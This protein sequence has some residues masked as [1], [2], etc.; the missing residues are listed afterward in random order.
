MNRRL[1]AVPIRP[2][3]HFSSAIAALSKSPP[4][5]SRFTAFGSACENSLPL[6]RLLEPAG[7]VRQGTLLGQ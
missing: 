3:Q 1:C 7:A 2:L 4:L 5:T 6:D